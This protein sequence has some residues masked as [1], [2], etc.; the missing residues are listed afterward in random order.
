MIKK[1]RPAGSYSASRVWKVVAET[2]R[3][4][5]SDICE[6]TSLGYTTVFRWVACLVRAGLLDRKDEAGV[7]FFSVV[8]G[9]TIDDVHLA[10]GAPVM[11]REPRE[12]KPPRTIPLFGENIGRFSSVWQM[13]CAAQE[14]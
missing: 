8:D 13:A 3:V 9:K 7:Q 2:G 1:T 11:P 5:I 10:F 6:T 12:V 14:A 4:R